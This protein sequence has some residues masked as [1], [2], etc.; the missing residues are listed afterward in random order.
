M[1]RLRCPFA[2]DPTHTD[3]IGWGGDDMRDMK[4]SFCDKGRKEVA[5]LVASG[6]A[7]ICD[8]CLVVSFAIMTG[9]GIKFM[10]PIKPQEPA[11]ATKPRYSTGNAMNSYKTAEIAEDMKSR[12]AGR[13][14]YEVATFRDSGKVVWAVT[15][16]KAV[17]ARATCREY[18]EQIADSMNREAPR[19]GP[20]AGAVSVIPQKT[21]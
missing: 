14:I 4:C 16:G 21:P 8:E 9:S 20:E 15:A 13:P 5:Q 3:G 10:T 17:L 2:L 1:C 7:A 6:S 11:Q 19:R 12:A 18:A